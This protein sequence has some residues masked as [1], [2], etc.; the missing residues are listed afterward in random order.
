MQLPRLFKAD[1]S[2][3]KKPGHRFS[4]WLKNCA[5][6]CQH[7]FQHQK[8]F[9]S[10]WTTSPP[11]QG[12]WCLPPFLPGLPTQMQLTLWRFSA[13]CR[14]KVTDLNSICERQ[15]QTSSLRLFVW[16]DRPHCCSMWEKSC[17]ALSGN[18]VY[19][20]S[21]GWVQVCSSSPGSGACAL[22]TE[23]FRQTPVLGA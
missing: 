8:L 16:K 6:A 5:A 23:N 4:A 10:F 17:S 20:F 14:R 11:R 15:T 21:W 9:I 12:W 19:D 1:I 7:P 22:K 18:G 2:R 3:R 13:T